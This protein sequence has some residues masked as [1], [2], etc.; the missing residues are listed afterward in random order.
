MKNE[1]SDT[2]RKPEN[3]IEES[4]PMASKS[5][6]KIEELLN[7]EPSEG[8]SKTDDVI[9]SFRD[10]LE[11]QSG[12]IK[13]CLD[14]ITAVAK[15]VKELKAAEDVI[16]QLS[17]KCRQLS[18]GFHEREVLFPVFF[19]LISIADRSHQ[20]IDNFQQLLDKQPEP[21]NRS[22]IKA[23]SYLIEARKA[24]LVEI[25]NKLADFRVESFE[26]HTDVFEPSVQKCIS[27]V[28]HQEEIAHG[29]IVQRI[30]PGY[31]R[32]DKIIRHEYVSV[33]VPASKDNLINGGK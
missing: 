33:Y 7:E 4:L 5:C 23:I 25:E 8:D 21:K 9:K 26:H 2:N 22:A 3:A 18:E 19:C 27:R 32:G 13:S 6:G 1:E 14:Q 12:D 11:S 20:Q 24:D 30:L 15:E 17:S 10:C 29:K 28:E 31:K 16:T